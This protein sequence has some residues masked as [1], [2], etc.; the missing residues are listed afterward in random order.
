M[1]LVIKFMTRV[2]TGASTKHL[3]H[4]NLLTSLT[5]QTH[6]KGEGAK[7]IGNVLSS[8]EQSR[9]DLAEM[10]KNLDAECR[11]CAPI[12]PLECITRCQVWKLKN[13]LRS[14]REIMGNPN[15]TKELLNALKNQT[16]VNILKSMV[17]TRY[18][19]SRLQQELK[20][21][22]Q[23]CS[24]EVISEEYIQP[25]VALGLAVQAREEYYATN[26]GGQLSQVIGDT[27]PEFSTLPAHSE[28]YEE[29]LLLALL[30]GP[31]TFEEIKQLIS[32]SIASRI[33][34]RLKATG[35]IE[36]PEERDYIFFFKTKRDPS[37][38]QL[39]PMEEKV[40]SNIADEGMSAK[41]ISKKT[42][43][44]IRIIY[45]HLRKLKGKKLIFVRKA[46]KPYDLTVKGKEFAEV[47]QELTQLVDQTWTST[48]QV[49]NGK[50]NS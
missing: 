36:R 9:Q 6:A 34:K 22:G 2:M 27:T 47:L 46:P 43:L 31:K 50:M 28:C 23:L 13:E 45:K 21:N 40:Y 35:L 18:S 14:L 10:L 49:V 1:T 24:V 25:L 48:E 39:N 30:S 19:I 17:K 16:R 33:L 20:K 8:N 41:N 4:T 7:Q 15:F 38:E 42:G 26:F 32:P 11:N 12:T 37:R 3:S 44:S 29:T 5:R